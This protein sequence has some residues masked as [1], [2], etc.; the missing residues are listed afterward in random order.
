MD[1]DRAIEILRPSEVLGVAE[2]VDRPRRPQDGAGRC[3][4]VFAGSLEAAGRRADEGRSLVAEG[5]VQS[6]EIGKRSADAHLVGSERAR[7]LEE[8]RPPQR[9][10][11]PR[12]SADRVASAVIEVRQR[13]GRLPSRG[14]RAHPLVDR[15]RCGPARLVEG[16][17]RDDA[18]V[19]ADVDEEID[20]L[21]SVR[22]GVRRRDLRLRDRSSFDLGAGLGV[23]VRAGISGRNCFFFRA[24]LG[25]GL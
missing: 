22:A 12:T 17:K 24:G 14:A 11:E 8:Q 9:K 13:R 10:L 2:A 16:I 5:A 23:R 4:A 1:S 3:A 18:R 21:A 6:T 7:V 25:S 19:V 20:E 15:R